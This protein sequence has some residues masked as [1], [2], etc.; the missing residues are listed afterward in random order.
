MANGRR[1]KTRK[2]LFDLGGG[3]ITTLPGVSAAQKVA[4]AEAQGRQVGAAFATRGITDADRLEIESEPINKEEF[5]E[6][7]A[8]QDEEIRR[9]TLPGRITG[10]VVG[11]TSDAA[12]LADEAGVDFVLPSQIQ[13][14]PLEQALATERSKFAGGP[15]ELGAS[16]PIEDRRVAEGEIFDE[17]TGTVQRAESA[18]QRKALT[19]AEQKQRQEQ[20]PLEAQLAELREQLGSTLAFNRRFSGAK[21]LEAKESAKAQIGGEIKQLEDRL[22]ANRNAIIAEKKTAT[23]LE[24]ELRLEGE[25]ARVAAESRERIDRANR[26]QK[27][28]QFGTLSAADKLKFGLDAAKVQ[29]EQKRV[30]EQVA[31]GEFARDPARLQAQLEKEKREALRDE[32]MARFNALVE[33]EKTKVGKKTI[34]EDIFDEE[35]KVVVGRTDITRPTGTPEVPELETVPVPDA[36]R[37]TTSPESVGDAN[38]DGRIDSDDVAFAKAVDRVDRVKNSPLFEGLNDEEIVIKIFKTVNEQKGSAAA[39]LAVD[40]YKAAKLLVKENNRGK[41]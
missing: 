16:V 38:G 34:S 2:E 31:A 33:F 29:L 39:K 21:T 28:F 17:A 7:A 5:P 36:Q 25:S 19:P 6:L 18:G 27:A 26:I 13:K 15:L 12:R 14:N 10:P 35:G 4:L 37:P 30:A 11:E 23:D 1:R 22:A 32:N 41:Q 24:S 9:A 20:G 40:N 8:Q 3:A